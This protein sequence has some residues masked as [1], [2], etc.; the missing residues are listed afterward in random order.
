MGTQYKGRDIMAV[1]LLEAGMT[2]YRVSKELNMDVALVN[3]IAKRHRLKL[4]KNESI[5]VIDIIDKIHSEWIVYAK[6]ELSRRTTASKVAKDLGY[7]Y[8]KLL[9]MFYVY[10]DSGVEID[11]TYEIYKSISKVRELKI[12]EEE[13]LKKII[14]GCQRTC[15]SRDMEIGEGEV[16]VIL[17]GLMYKGVIE[18]VQEGISM[19]RKR[20]AFLEVERLREK[21]N[22]DGR[23]L[24]REAVIKE[25]GI[26]NWLIACDTKENSIN[27]STQRARNI[28]GINIDGLRNMEELKEIRQHVIDTIKSNSDIDSKELYKLIVQVLRKYNVGT[29]S[30]RVMLHTIGV[31]KRWVEKNGISEE[32]CKSIERM[33][34]DYKYSV[35]QT[36]EYVRDNFNIQVNSRVIYAIMYRYKFLEWL[37]SDMRK[38]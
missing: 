20:E 33:I 10:E 9:S 4:T 1:K 25:I 37:K 15:I 34:I 19:E 24:D 8:Y 12:K 14:D 11:N 31:E 30:Y 18:S 32:I 22:K 27:K 6:S 17:H 5:K 2:R 3:S 7:S 23:V 36:I 29:T 28:D 26:M 35:P 16:W 21:Y 38:K 13:V